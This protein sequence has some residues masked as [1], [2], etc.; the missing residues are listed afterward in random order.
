MKKEE[1]EGEDAPG[2]ESAR[3]LEPEPEPKK[4]K[5]EV[6]EAKMRAPDVAPKTQGKVRAPEVAPKTEVAQQVAPKTEVAQPSTLQSSVKEEHMVKA[7]V[8]GDV[9]FAAVNLISD[10][11]RLHTSDVEDS[12]PSAERAARKT[13][14]AAKT[15]AKAPWHAHAR[16]PR[17]VPHAPKGPPPQH[18]VEM[19][20]QETE[21]MAE[22]EWV[23][24]KH[25]P[26]GARVG[27]GKGKGKGYAAPRTPPKAAAPRTPP[28]AK[29]VGAPASSPYSI[30]SWSQPPA[31][32]TLGKGQRAIGA[33]FVEPRSMWLDEGPPAIGAAIGARGSASSAPASSSG[34]SAP[35]SSSAPAIG[36]T[37]A[38]HGVRR[39]GW[40]RKC[41]LLSEALL[42]DNKAEAKQLANEF[43]SGPR[44]DF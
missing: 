30:W 44:D 11:E 2:V 9:M 25:M 34:S 24:A 21:S 17:L 6:V 18:L 31:S 16:R 3:W 40:F 15:I 35:A 12:P 41:Q 39:G 33:G 43:Y 26:A 22:P 42:A 27:K 8:K 5:L 28:K 19:A 14:T 38:A 37:M 13:A 4:A 36:N 23:K 29:W 1:A 20:M 10:D 7:E 32:A